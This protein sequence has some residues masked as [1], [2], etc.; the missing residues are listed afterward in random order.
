MCEHLQRKPIVADQAIKDLRRA[1]LE[2]IDAA[3]GKL[4]EQMVLATA[5]AAVR[6]A[7]RQASP[8]E[9]LSERVIHLVRA[10]LKDLAQ[11]KWKPD[12]ALLL[13]RRLSNH[14]PH[15]SHE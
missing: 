13:K 1:K 9:V 6:L 11:H 2:I 4:P 7:R 15:E 12:T 3:L 8:Q 14:E 5:T 10:T